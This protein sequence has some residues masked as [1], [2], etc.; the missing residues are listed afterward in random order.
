MR[1]NQSLVRVN[2]SMSRVNQSLAVEMIKTITER[3]RARAAGRA[4]LTAAE[5]RRKERARKKAR[6]DGNARPIIGVVYD[7]DY[8]NKP[9]Q[10]RLK[11]LK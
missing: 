8:G 2:Q 3:M 7:E 6:L 10:I 1:L 5:C 9:I 4:R 11:D